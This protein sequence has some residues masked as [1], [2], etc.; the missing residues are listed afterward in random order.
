M[1][2]VLA[3]LV[4]LARANDCEGVTAATLK[5]KT[6]TVNDSGYTYTI[7]VGQGGEINQRKGGDTWYLGEHQN[8]PSAM[9]EKFYNG[10]SCPNP[11]PK[12]SAKITYSFGDSTKIL[13]A[14]EPSTCYYEFRVQIDKSVCAGLGGGEA[15]KVGDNVKCD[16]KRSRNCKRRNCCG[17]VPRQGNT[18]GFCQRDEAQCHKKDK[19]DKTMAWGKQ[20]DGCSHLRPRNL[21]LSVGRCAWTT[22]GK[23]HCMMAS[24]DQNCGDIES[25]P[26]C[27]DAGCRWRGRLEL[28]E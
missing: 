18:P 14:S 5:G 20:R 6:F 16:G 11:H 12:R 3:L 4:S 25:K 19:K 17:W 10:Q 24:D 7:K 28:C 9:E 22:V 1:I 23:P 21:C 26:L 15:P 27:K 13:S 8:Y 2:Y